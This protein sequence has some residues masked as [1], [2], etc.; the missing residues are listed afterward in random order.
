MAINPITGVEEDNPSNTDTSPVTPEPV[1]APTPVVAPPMAPPSAAPAPAYTFGQKDPALEFGPTSTPNLANYDNLYGKV[2]NSVTGSGN[3]PTTVVSDVEKLGM[4][5]PVVQDSTKSATFLTDAAL[6]KTK[7]DYSPDSPGYLEWMKGAP[8]VSPTGIA[9][10]T[11]STVAPGTG[12]VA[13]TNYDTAAKTA[14]TIAPKTDFTTA[15]SPDQIK[16]M[17]DKQIFEGNMKFLEA[18]RKQALGEGGPSAAQAQLQAGTDKNIATMQAQAAAQRGQFNPALMRAITAQAAGARQEGAGQAAMLRAQE[19]QAAQKLA[20]ELGTTISGQTITA[21]QGQDEVTAAVKS[22][23]ATRVATVLSKVIDNDTTTKIQN[24]VNEIDLG[25]FNVSEENKIKIKN[26][27]NL[28][29]I[30][31]IN[32][33]VAAEIMMTNLNASIAQD[34][35]ARDALVLGGMTDAA[36]DLEIKKFNALRRDAVVKNVLDWTREGKQ[37]DMDTRIKLQTMKDAMMLN[38]NAQNLDQVTKD[39][40]WQAEIERLR[41][42]ALAIERGEKPS[43][44]SWLEKAAPVLLQV[45]GTVAAAAITSGAAA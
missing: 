33:G 10:V 30:A 19:Q 23:D 13:P 18:I 45:A 1:V 12:V 41:L 35:S 38:M 31:R 14:E 39:R 15:Y 2:D 28:L 40:M 17:Q 27:D 34:K 32:T 26:A 37:L 43:E 36:A 29:D 7:V 5:T 42:N 21:L 11:A 20:G 24:A 4:G 3:N 9:D 16:A 22:G 25:K 44:G 8:T 6:D